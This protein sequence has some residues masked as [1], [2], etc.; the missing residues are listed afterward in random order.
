M[1]KLY[2][3]LLCVLVFT[4]T[5][6]YGIFSRFTHAVKNGYA[7]SYASLKNIARHSSIYAKKAFAP[8][9]NT[10]R[11]TIYTALYGGG[12]FAGIVSSL[13]Y[14]KKK[15]EKELVS[16]LRAPTPLSAFTAVEEFITHRNDYHG[17]WHEACQKMYET[18]E[19]KPWGAIV[20]KYH[21]ALQQ[22]QRELDNEL[23]TL[24][25]ITHAEWQQFKKDA[26]QAFVEYARKD[27][28]IQKAQTIGEKLDPR[29]A[30]AI[31]RACVKMGFNDTHLQIQLAPLS[32]PSTMYAWQHHIVINQKLS[33]LP[34]FSSDERREVSVAREL[35]H[36]YHDDAF[37]KYCIE[38]LYEEKAHLN[39]TQEQH[40]Q[41][42][43]KVSHFK[44]ER[45]DT[46]VALADI[47]YAYTGRE[48]FKGFAEPSFMARAAFK[49]MGKDIMDPSPASHPTSKY[50]YACVATIYQ[51]IKDFYAA[52][53]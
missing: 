16:S 19:A 25:G 51:D 39:V 13:Y 53:P 45:A 50:R 36:M 5:S 40:Q 41:F 4:H 26:Q 35:C 46:L 10:C 29:M 37:D 30:E 20:K 21:A 11:S 42:K 24:Y 44:E 15:G 9:T 6:S 52:R 34:L 43:K 7:A 27:V 2:K 38:R 31:K 49:T 18:L 17:P 23:Y 48:L 12:M 8:L 33:F 1:V 32:M 3:V 47:D 28:E 14:L 22:R